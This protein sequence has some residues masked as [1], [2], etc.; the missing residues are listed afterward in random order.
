MK[1]HHPSHHPL[2]LASFCGA[3]LSLVSTPVFAVDGTWD[4][5]G[6]SSIWGGFNN[7]DPNGQIGTGVDGT[8]TFANAFANGRAILLNT[9]R[10]LGHVVY[11]DPE[12]VTAMTVSWHSNNP[13]SVLTLAVNSGK[14]TFDVTQED[15]TLT[16][17]A[18]LGGTKG[19]D[20]VGPGTLILDIP[21]S[22]PNHIVSGPV[23]ITEGILS[24][25]ESEV[26]ANAI[27]DTTSSV[28]GDATNGLSTT[29]TALSFAGISGDKDLASLFTTN[30]GGFDG[31]STLTLN[32]AAGASV[33]YSGA[34][35]D[36][37]V[38][39]ALVKSGAGTQTLAGSG[40]YTG[41]TWVDEG[42]LNFSTGS[43]FVS[44]ITVATTVGV[45]VAAND[46]QWASAGDLTLSDNSALAI[47]FGS[48]TP[49]TTVAPMK[50]DNLS[51]G[52]G[53][54]LEI[55]ANPV[56]SLAA[57][58]SFPLVTWA[59]SGPADASSFTA[60]DL[61]HRVSGNLSVVGSTLFLNITANTAGP[62]AW[63]TGDGVWDTSTSNWLDVTASPTTYFDPLD[64]V[65]FGDA[66]GVTGNPVVTINT[67]LSPVGMTM[68]TSRS[69]TFSGSGGIDGTGSLALDPANTGT[70]TIE[71]ANSFSGDI[72][73]GGGTLEANLAESGGFT[74]LGN[75]SNARTISVAAGATLRFNAANVFNGN[76]ASTSVPSLVVNGGTVTNANPLA[77]PNGVNNA[78]NN[79]SL[80][81]GTLQATVGQLN[82]YA[83]WNVN[84][85]ITSSGSSTI[86]STEPVSGTVML[87]S[88]GAAGVATATAIDVQDGTLTISAPLVEGTPDGKISSLTKLG[89]GTLVLEGATSYTGA[90]TISAGTLKLGAAEL[91]PD[92][93]GVGNLTVDGV[94][95]LN[96]FSESVNGLSGSGTIDSNVDAAITLTVGGNDAGGTFSGVIQNTAGTLSF[97]KIGSGTLTLGGA[98][99]FTGSTT[100]SDGILSLSDMAALSTTTALALADGT[101]L[102]STLGGVVIN[103]P[104]TL[105]TTGTNATISAPV[106]DPG[107]Q[108][109]VLL[110][111]NGGISGDGNVTFTSS[112]NKNTV[113][114]VLLNAQSSY[115]GSTLLDTSGTAATQTFVRLGTDN[116]L[117]T[118]TVVTIDGKNGTGTGRRIELDLN[119][120]NQEIAGLTNVTRNLR[121]QRVV[122][123]DSA[124]AATLT[125][126]NSSDY[127]YSGRL[128]NA[129]P[130]F[131]LTKSGS[132]IFT[133]SG[134]LEY[135]GDTTV[136]AGTLS[137]ERTNAN[138]DQS[139]VTIAASGAK[140]QLAYAGTDIV[141]KLIIGATEYGAGSYGHTDSGATNGGA[142]VGAL[143]AFF[144]PGTGTLT[145]QGGYADWA[146]TNAPTT[147]NNLDADEDGDGVNNGAEY[148]LGGTIATNDIDK[149]PT[150]STSG[151]N[152]SFTFN[153][154]QASIDGTTV[155]T[156]EVGTD[157]STWPDSYLVPDA[158]AASD[159][160][161]TVIKDL[162]NTGFDI[163]TLSVP[164]G[165]DVR[166]FAR[167][168]ISVP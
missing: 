68:N 132:G 107:S 71:T 102:R 112:V 63:N 44:D 135:A 79:V 8:A 66:T 121:V 2:T 86:S 92:G 76:F 127:T 3:F 60:L 28:V 64:L 133:A 114:T 59:A 11:T 61:P 109:P 108:T 35:A 45:L 165:G 32:P 88:T 126:N 73:I 123:S 141:G 97:E 12:V 140:L 25:V 74:A 90:T 37:A 21:G 82:G 19:F 113:N 154:D 130:N 160:G 47:D 103:A 9:S 129:G 145:I 20:K 122:N 15:R 95:E 56:S 151:G 38:G 81:G 69:Y 46:G 119:G 36:G 120:F 111:L 30:G 142:G 137:L 70:L 158:A 166:K 164:Q 33:A 75:P 163:V 41:A 23:A 115:A 144:E 67:G 40:S 77:L 62:I 65:L 152:M 26:L 84:G 6:N 58:Q 24:L 98:N 78:L 159:P 150:V 101:L 116:A 117:P 14:P 106:I 80:N 161:V 51:P 72:S 18:R 138:N 96:G 4:G 54:I 57:G 156:I 55:D 39:M 27:L 91:V 125:I 162:P 85:T 168:Q 17:T 134:V 100:V 29:A 7:W 146:A 143:D 16:V 10:S 167:L 13:G 53:L 22:A 52:T 48:S 104:I 43:T 99:T 128:G 89:D 49:S 110:T 5:G 136:T 83:A 118:T 157:L 148:V 31:V 147:G 105:G 149:L 34:I 87:N 50:V 1:N 42:R 93:S 139:I 94:L 153:R 155:V 131:G 124:P